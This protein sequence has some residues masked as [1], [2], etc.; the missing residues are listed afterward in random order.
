MHTTAAAA[1]LNLNCYRQTSS[2]EQ[3]LNH[4]CY[5]VHASEQIRDLMWSECTE[6]WYNTSSS[7]QYVYWER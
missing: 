4:W 5:P 3:F 6:T 1:V 2:I 7:H